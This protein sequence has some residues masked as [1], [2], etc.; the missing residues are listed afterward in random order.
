MLGEDTQGPR[1]LFVDQKRGDRQ[2]ASRAR[3]AEAGCRLNGDP[4]Q[5]GLHQ[6]VSPSAVSTS[7]DGARPTIFHEPTVKHRV[8]LKLISKNQPSSTGW[9]DEDT[10]VNENYSLI[11]RG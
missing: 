9:R 2:L 10:K 3:L 8:G 4:T 7:L 6:P 11:T 5:S 1:E